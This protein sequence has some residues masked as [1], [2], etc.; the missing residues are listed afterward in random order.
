MFFVVLLLGLGCPTVVRAAF[1]VRAV[2]EIGNATAPPDDET[3]WRHIKTNIRNFLSSHDEH[4]HKFEYKTDKLT[5]VLLCIPFL[6]GL[7]GLGRFY[8]EYNLQGVMQLAATI[9]GVAAFLIAAVL[10]SGLFMLV[11]V[12][13]YAAF[14]CCIYWETADAFRIVFGD[15]HP[16]WGDWR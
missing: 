13:L 7:F 3:L 5:A 11:A 2:S 1:P 6:G 10:Q 16:K 4:F 14:L 15:L 8:M 9:L 12:P